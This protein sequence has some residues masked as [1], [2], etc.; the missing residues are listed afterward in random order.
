MYIDTIFEI[1][2]QKF[3]DNDN[4][5]TFQAKQKKIYFENIDYKFNERS[6]EVLKN[7]NITINELD[8]IGLIGKTGSGKSTFANLILKL[9]NPSKGKIINNF[10]KISFV[11]QSPYLINGSIKDNI[12][13]GL[14]KDEINDQLIKKCLV[15]SQLEDFIGSL[16]KGIETRIGDRGLAISGGELQRI[17]I[18]RALYTNPD[19]IIFDEATN[20]LDKRY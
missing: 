5:N 12:A 3:V 8:F 17:A 10:E 7:I 19:L 18:A 4:E 13:F 15:D 20:A 2:N 6:E 1:F 14:K 11:P 16:N 9:L